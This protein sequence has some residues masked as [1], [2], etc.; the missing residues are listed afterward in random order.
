VPLKLTMC[1]LSL[2]LSL[3]VSDPL[4][5][6]LPKGLKVTLNVQLA[7]EASELPQLFV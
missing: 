2:A 3:I 4:R 6:P 5:N 1:G 7:P